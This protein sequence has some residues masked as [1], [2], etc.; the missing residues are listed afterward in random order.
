MKKI[1]NKIE[2][3]T[4]YLHV[5]KIGFE[6]RQL[7]FFIPLKFGTESIDENSEIYNELIKFDSVLLKIIMVN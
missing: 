4:E 6:Y 1:V 7:E 5:K 3:L 2:Q